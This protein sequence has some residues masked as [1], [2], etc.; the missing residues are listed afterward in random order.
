MGRIFK[1][2][3]LLS[4]SMLLVSCGLSNGSAYVTAC[5]VNADQA[6]T[7]EGRW[8]SLRTAGTSVPIAFHTGDFT[9]AEMTS[10][11]TAAQTW[12]QF[13]NA[14]MGTTYIDYGSESSPRTSSITK[15]SHSCADD[16]S[17]LN[18]SGGFTSP[19]VIYKDLTWPA[20]LATAAIAVTTFCTN[21]TP[22]IHTLTYA[23]IEINYQ[24]FFDS[25]QYQPDLQSVVLH[26][27]GHMAGLYHS[28][29]TGL[30]TN[31][32]CDATG[33]ESDYLSAVMYPNFTFS[34]TTYLGNV[35]R[36]LQPNDEGRANCLYQN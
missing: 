28:C 10:I 29:G 30:G 17:I 24:S 16:S 6:S 18:D 33:I 21:N 32:D 25:A 8:D 27:F 23:F 35:N 4:T 26:E 15:G 20:D 13:F 14:S 36:E 9:S 1:L 22:T 19:V 11:V 31:P 34:P 2:L 7:F 3:P 5:S 12:N